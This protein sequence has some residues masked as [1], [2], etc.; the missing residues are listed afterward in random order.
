MIAAGI[1]NTDI[2][3][4]LLSE[5]APWNA[6][7]REYLCAGDYAA[8]NGH[9]LCTDAILNHAVMSELL[10]SLA[11]DKI[12]ENTNRTEK[13]EQLNAA[14]LASR[15]EYAG[16]GKCL[17]DTNTQ[18]AVMMDWETPIMEK[19]AAWICHADVVGSNNDN[20]PPLNI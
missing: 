5:G 17:V 15:L 7:D 20:K 8:K 3:N 12:I 14:Y 6:V 18:L 11:V 10:L 9:Q 16:D 13:T 19:H 1:G 2:V 4:Y